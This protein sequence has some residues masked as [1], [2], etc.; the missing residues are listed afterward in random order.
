[1]LLSKKS[2][3]ASKRMMALPLTPI[4]NV[5]LTLKP[6][7]TNSWGAMLTSRTLQSTKSLTSFGTTEENKA[8]GFDR[9]ASN[10]TSTEL[11]TEL[12]LK[13]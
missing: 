10:M 9:R 11:Q 8:L 7:R 13:A 5:N 4:S 3:G 2:P 12:E 6:P 1:M